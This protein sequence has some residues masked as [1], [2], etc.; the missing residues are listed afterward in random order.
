M[1]IENKSVCDEFEDDCDVSMRAMLKEQDM[2]AEPLPDAEEEPRYVGSDSVF[3]E[4]SLADI[5]L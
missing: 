1:S 3:K 4:K 2:N 5:E